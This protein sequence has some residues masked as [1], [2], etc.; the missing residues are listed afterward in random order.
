MTKYNIINQVKNIQDKID[1]KTLSASDQP[2]LNQVDQLI[3]KGMLFS[4]YKIK[5]SKFTHPWSP[6]LTV[7]IFSV[8]IFKLHLSSVQNKVCKTKIIDILYKT[9]LSYDIPHLPPKLKTNDKKTIINELKQASK[10]LTL[11]KKMQ[12]L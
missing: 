11:I 6:T 2:Y 4:E 1:S 5:A 8:S 3:T 10:N 7:A 12:H 9:M